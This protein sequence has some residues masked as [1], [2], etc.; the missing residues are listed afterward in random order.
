MAKKK[1]ATAVPGKR[2]A[3]KTTYTMSVQ[4]IAEK[5]SL[6]ASKVH[7]VIESLGEEI[8]RTL[9][10]QGR[11]RLANYG[12]FQVKTLP[13]RKC[14]NPRTGD[15][16]EVGERQK[17]RF[18]AGSKLVGPVCGEEGEVAAPTAKSTAKKKVTKKK[19]TKKKTSKKTELADTSPPAEPGPTGPVA[20][21]ES[22]LDEDFDIDGEPNNAD[23]SGDADEFDL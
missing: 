3:L 9:V 13:P 17:I 19:A 23:A 2:E 11:F 1:A 6:P 10:D 21:P 12:S 18:T 16:I 4:L 20:D 22:D 5:V 14:R 15:T 8:A 7:Q